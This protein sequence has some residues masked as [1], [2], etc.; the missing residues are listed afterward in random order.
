MCY[1]CGAKFKYSLVIGGEEMHFISV[2][3]AVNGVELEV[4]R[5]IQNSRGPWIDID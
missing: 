4:K 5:I 3:Y 2:P 1:R